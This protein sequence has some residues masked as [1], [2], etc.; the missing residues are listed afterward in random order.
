[1]KS[2]M[3]RAQ[4][5]KREQ[6]CND[7]A[8]AAAVDDGYGNEVN[9]IGANDVGAF[10]I[11]S[12]DHLSPPLTRICSFY[13]SVANWGKRLSSHSVPFFA[14]TLSPFLLS[15]SPLFSL[16]LAH[17]QPSHGWE[18]ILSSVFLLRSKKEEKKEIRSKHPTWYIASCMHKTMSCYI[19]CIIYLYFIPV[20]SSFEFFVVAVVSKIF[21]PFFFHSFIR[22]LYALA[23]T[24]LALSAMCERC[25]CWRSRVVFS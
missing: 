25:G 3:P 5:K 17:T 22:S 14:Q 16:S 12:L 8:A 19:I 9:D 18:K 24:H 13:F 11:F 21:G 2:E 4:K 10:M 1:M 6:T 20:N 23:H 15:L 7:T